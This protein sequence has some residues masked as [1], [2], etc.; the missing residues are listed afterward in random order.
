M[1][2]DTR[3]P[4]VSGKAAPRSEVSQLSS[5]QGQIHQQTSFTHKT[6]NITA[7]EK[8]KLEF[9]KCSVQAAR[10]QGHLQVQV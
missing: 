8:Q 1:P 2:K 5:L 7:A 3:P 10:L 4:W 6:A 9:L